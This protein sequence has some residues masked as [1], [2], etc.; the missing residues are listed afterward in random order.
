M[1]TEQ[2]HPLSEAYDHEA[3]FDAN[4]APH[5]HAIYDECKRLR[6]PMLIAVGFGN[7]PQDDGNGTHVG[8][9]VAVHFAGRERTPPT[10]IAAA[11]L[12]EGKTE[13][14]LALAVAGGLFGFDT[15][16]IS[17]ESLLPEGQTN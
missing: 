6:L 16:E 13:E 4:I 3:E 17:R 1:S 10:M 7:I 12:V 8:Q 2:K 5:I 11:K 14:A 15:T 9:S